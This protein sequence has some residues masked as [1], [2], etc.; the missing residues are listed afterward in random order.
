MMKSLLIWFTGAVL[1]LAAAS[2]VQAAPIQD[3]ALN[4]Y[5][6][7]WYPNIYKENGPLSCP[8]T[9]KRWISGTAEQER[10][11]E[12][13][14][15]GFQINLCKVVELHWGNPLYGSQF[16]EQAACYY[17]DMASSSIKSERFHCLCITKQ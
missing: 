3:G 4:N 16:N 1:L 15:K 17:Q 2:S 6:T 13:E 7:G 9:C 10:R 14:W 11:M 8:E 12:G 5:K